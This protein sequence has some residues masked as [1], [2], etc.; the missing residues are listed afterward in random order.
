MGRY[1]GACFQACLGPIT[2]FVGT[3]HQL[4]HADAETFGVGVAPW[5]EKTDWH[6]CCL[7]VLVRLVQGYKGLRVRHHLVLSS[8]GGTADIILIT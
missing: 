3:K 7:S 5:R 8:S 2:R 4:A 6:P 1:H